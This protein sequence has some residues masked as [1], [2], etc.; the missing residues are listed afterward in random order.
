MN[1][2]SYVDH[3]IRA[4]LTALALICLVASS[5]WA[6]TAGADWP[7]WRGPNA[8]GVA[9][10]QTWNPQALTADAK[11][12]WEIDVG[13][14]YSAVAVVGPLVYTMGNVDNTDIVYCLKEETGEEVW[15][16]SY[17][18]KADSYPGPRSTPTV[19]GGQVYTL[20]RDGRLFCLDAQSGAV[21][22]EKNITT[23]LGATPPRWGLAGSAVTVD[24]MLLVNAAEHGIALDKNTGQILW[25]SA[26]GI[27]GYST[28]VLARINGKPLVLLF[29][30]KALYALDLQSG[31][32]EWS[33]PW[34]TSYDVNASDPLVVGSHIFIS[35][36]YRRGC[37]LLD[38]GA[39]QPK[40]AWENKA[41]STHFSSSIELEGHIY[42]IDGNAGRGGK[43]VCIEIGSGQTVWDEP[44]GF[45]SFIMADRKLIVLTEKG[46]VIIA[47]A[48]PDGYSQVAAAEKLLPST[49]WTPP[50]LC[51][52][53]LY[54]RNEKGHLVCLNL[55]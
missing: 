13:A 2:T 11:R 14:G 25:K 40:V 47:N 51:R 53:L 12:Q 36:G 4:G 32:K 29:G 31:R 20:S 16:H 39:A 43:L 50:V 55:R 26:P 48:A 41:V 38:V 6:Q 23:D 9:P 35:S 52:G 10:A 21:K 8:D 37:S 54:L 19:D 34:I 22:W 18:C 17:P 44:V 30:E 15:R 1:R 7:R 5:A 24:N 33:H 46:S 3:T 28:P 42:G 27:S 49:C 45:G